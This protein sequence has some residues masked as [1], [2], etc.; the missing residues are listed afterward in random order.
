MEY[1][2]DV[3]NREVTHEYLKCLFDPS[4]TDAED[5]A[6]SLQTSEEVLRTGK[7]VKGYVV[8]TWQDLPICFVKVLLSVPVPP[9][10][11]S[12]EVLGCIPE[13]GSYGTCHDVAKRFYGNSDNIQEA[14]RVAAS[15]N[16]VDCVN[17]CRYACYHLGVPAYVF[18]GKAQVFAEYCQN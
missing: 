17:E 2:V 16:N 10:A 12:R 18:P 14:V 7:G 13:M 3:D 5:L 9:D 11:A 1:L 15:I 8:P 4:I 6:S